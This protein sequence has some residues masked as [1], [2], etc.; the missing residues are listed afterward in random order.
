MVRVPT[1]PVTPSIWSNDL[2]LSGV[3]HHSAVAV[4][5]HADPPEYADMR[6]PER[7]PHDRDWAGPAHYRAADDNQ[8][9]YLSPVMSQPSAIT[10]DHT[11]NMTTLSATSTWSS[12]SLSSTSR[13]SNPTVAELERLMTRFHLEH[14]RSDVYRFQELASDAKLSTIFVHIL[15]LEE[16]HAAR[17]TEY[18][19]LTKRLANIEKLCAQAWQP[20]KAQMKLIRGLIRHY[21]IQPIPNYNGIADQVKI[22]RQ[23]Y[24][25]K[26]PDKFRLQLYNTDPIVQVTVNGHISDLIA[27]MKSTFR[28]AVFTACKNRTSLDSFARNMVDNYHLPAIPAEIPLSILGTLAM[29]R[30]VADP[31]TK[32]PQKS[33]GGDTGFWR[34]VDAELDEIYAVPGVGKDRDKDPKWIEWAQQQVNNDRAR[35]SSRRRARQS[36]RTNGGSTVHD[37]A[38]VSHGQ[39]IDNDDSSMDADSPILSA[40]APVSGD[41]DEDMS[42]G[43]G[44]GELPPLNTFGDIASTITVAT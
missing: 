2:D 21:L 13:V 37:D 24:I 19:E 12:Q 18:I 6:R 36:R 27:Q 9:R 44:S 22:L 43:D 1:R 34:A 8:A 5:G 29:M 32:R 3:S 23:R 41:E 14:R 15:Q 17:R 4:L 30:R 7:V 42:G 20:S 38:S 28:K 10:R 25:K 35:F 16:T 31:L 26:N 33:R 11:H 40:H 39:G